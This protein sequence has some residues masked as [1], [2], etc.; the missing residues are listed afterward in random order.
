[1]MYTCFQLFHVLLYANSYF[2]VIQSFLSKCRRID[3]DGDCNNMEYIDF[4]SRVLRSIISP[5]NERVVERIENEQRLERNYVDQAHY[6]DIVKHKPNE[7]RKSVQTNQYEMVCLFNIHYDKYDHTQ[8][9]NI[10]LPPSISLSINNNNNNHSSRN[11]KKNGYKNG[12][13]Q[14][15]GNYK[16]N[17]YQAPTPAI[18]FLVGGAWGSCDITYSASAAS[19]FVNNKIAFIYP[20]YRIYPNGNVQDMLKNINSIIK[21][22][23][24]YHKVLNIN[25]NHIAIVGQSSGAHLG[26][27]AILKAYQEKFCVFSDCFHLLIL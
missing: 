21:W 20:K 27:L 4:S 2:Y 8:Y 13:K 23:I 19:S 3:I 11:G 10:F 25:P 9:V 17:L 18:I 6:D 22:I 14:K 26:A 16:R 24:K 7:I 5:I 15:N 12:T 1:M